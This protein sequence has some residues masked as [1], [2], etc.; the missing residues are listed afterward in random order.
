M[1]YSNH[2]ILTLSKTTNF[3]CDIQSYQAL[4]NRT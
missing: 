2:L 4:W 3:T 1:G